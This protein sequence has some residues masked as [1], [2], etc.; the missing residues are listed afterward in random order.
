MQDNDA[1][2]KNLVESLKIHKL[3]FITC[4]A[5]VFWPLVI[6]V[7]H[8][9][10][11]WSWE[12]LTWFFSHFIVFNFSISARQ[13]DRLRNTCTIGCNRHMSIISSMTYVICHYINVHWGSK[14][15]L[16]GQW[17]SELLQLHCTESASLFW[18]HYGKGKGII[19]CSLKY[20]CKLAWKGLT[21][22]VSWECDFSGFRRDQRGRMNA[23]NCSSRSGRRQAEGMQILQNFNSFSVSSTPFNSELFD[24]SLF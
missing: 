3:L 18:F 21:F 7:L 24:I 1:F 10:F 12:N 5:S 4:C 19:S 14:D 13:R 2:L 11:S 20:E 8:G 22:Y 16:F 23:T 15:Q 6:E 17:Q 9:N